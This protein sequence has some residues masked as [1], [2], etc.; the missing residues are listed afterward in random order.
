MSFCLLQAGVDG[1]IKQFVWGFDRIFHIK[2]L[3]FVRVFNGSDASR[4]TFV[5]CLF[6]AFI[7]V[8]DFAS[9]GFH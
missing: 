4:T 7:C 2:K 8:Y 6:I 3:I 9:S 5:H 1:Q